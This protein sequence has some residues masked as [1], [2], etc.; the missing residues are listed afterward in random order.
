MLKSH[1]LEKKNDLYKSKLNLN[2][3]KHWNAKAIN[4]YQYVAI[5]NGS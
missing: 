4:W 1:T 3:Q 5:K 2:V